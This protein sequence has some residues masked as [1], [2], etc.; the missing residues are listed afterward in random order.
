MKRLMASLVGTIGGVVLA[1]N[2]YAHG[3]GHPDHYVA[4]SGVDKGRCIDAKN[5]CRTILYALSTASKGEKVLVAEGQYELSGEDVFFLM[6]EMTPV[7]GGYS[8]KDHFKTSNPEQNI[9]TIIGLPHQYRDKL[10]DKGLNLLQDSKKPFEFTVEQKKMWEIYSL[11]TTMFEG[12]QNCENGWAGQYECNNVDLMSHIPLSKF[13]TNPGSANDI[14]GFVDLNDGREYAI[15]GL[16]NG[17]AVVDVTAAKA[18]KEVGTISGRNSTWR[19]IKVYQHFNAATNRYDSFAYVTTEARQGMQ[20]IDLRELPEKI[21]LAHTYE[22]FRTAHNVYIGNVDYATGMSLPGQNAYLYISG[23]NLNRGSFRVLDLKNPENPQEVSKA[24]QG[25]G[26]IHDAT[27]LVIDDERTS[28]CAVGHHPCEIMVDFN[29]S[30][31]DIWDTTDKSKPYLIS[32]TGYQGAAYTHSGWWS[33]DK[34]YIFVHDELDEQNSGANTTIR[35]LDITNLKQPYVSNVWTGPTQAIDH[36]GF[37]KGD[38]Y[39][40]SNYRRGLGILDISEPN[41]PVEMGFFDT[42]PVPQANSAHFNGAWGTYPY[43]PSGNILVSDIEYGLYV[44]REGVLDAKQ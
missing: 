27:N 1:V 36:N 40:Y 5:P 21:S 25:T 17:T 16:E 31:V 11:S 8:V 35:T 38:K 42:F 33:K 30:T 26:Y 44:V 41:R 7:L 34:K 13:S 20:V 29:E 19:D 18:P 9:T 22:G 15:I 28:A 24:P 23:S 12:P 3:G 32:A 39:Y 2:V 43:L 37:V 4:E 14:W 10:A 6:S